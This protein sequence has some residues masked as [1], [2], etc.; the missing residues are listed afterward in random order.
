M[1]EFLPDLHLSVRQFATLV[2]HGM[3]GHLDLAIVTHRR[4]HSADRT[5][6]IIIYKS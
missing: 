3:I 4:H 2:R 6:H 5:H 1:G